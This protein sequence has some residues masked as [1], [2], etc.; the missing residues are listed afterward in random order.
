LLGQDEQTVRSAYVATELTTWAV[1]VPLAFASLLTGLIVALGTAWGLFRH[2][3]VFVKFMLTIF[4]T[5]LLLLHN[6]TIGRL[7]SVARQTAV[8]GADAHGLQVQLVGDAT[9]A[10]LA[11]LVNV[12]LSIY[13]PQGLTPYGRRKQ[14]EQR[15][16]AEA[17]VLGAA[18]R[19]PRW[20]QGLAIL[21]V[22]LILAFIV[23]HLSGRGLG[24]LHHR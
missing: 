4:A 8:S 9:A 18:T 5:V 11:L 24:T 16:V 17:D 15:Q 7:G 1:I 13:K 23:L 6:Q 22:A 12:T 14:L 10:L 21:V 3:W 2:Y 19:S 20:I